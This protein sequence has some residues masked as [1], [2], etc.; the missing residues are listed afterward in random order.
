METKE[1]KQAYQIALNSYY[2]SKGYSNGIIYTQQDY[3]KLYQEMISEK[4]IEKRNQKINQI[5][6][7][8]L[9]NGK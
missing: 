1:Q 9:D 2:G 7:E 6:E 8:K 3:Q 4:I 5:L